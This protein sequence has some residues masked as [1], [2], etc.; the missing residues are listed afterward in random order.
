M[1]DKDDRIVCAGDLY[2]LL[3]LFVRVIA[4]HI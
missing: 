3:L 4:N 2:S 1:M